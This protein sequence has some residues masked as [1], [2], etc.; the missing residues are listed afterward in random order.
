MRPNR[1]EWGNDVQFQPNLQ[2][3]VKF[4]HSAGYSFGMVTI[5]RDGDLRDGDQVTG[6]IIVSSHRVILWKFNFLLS[7]YTFYLFIHPQATRLWFSYQCWIL[8]LAGNLAS[9]SLQEVVSF[10]KRT[11][12]HPRGGKNN[13]VSVNLFLNQKMFCESIGLSWLF[14]GGQE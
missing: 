4:N 11:T 13:F 14:D 5:L 7:Y 10:P 6:G 9:S 1:A 8:R 2:T 12:C 3:N